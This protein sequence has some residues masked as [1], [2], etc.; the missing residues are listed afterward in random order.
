MRL[1]IGRI[2]MTLGNH[3]ETHEPAFDRLP[4]VFPTGALT[5]F[6]ERL[7]RYAYTEKN[8]PI[9][10]AIEVGIRATHLW[11][12]GARSAGPA[13]PERVSPQIEAQACA[14]TAQWNAKE[15]RNS[16]GDSDLSEPL[17][18]WTAVEVEEILRAHVEA[19]IYHEGVPAPDDDL[20][21]SEEAI[22]ALEAF[23]GN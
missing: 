9:A 22:I 12:G 23:I 7:A 13:N 2:P 4:W 11:C 5:P 10:S 17:V 16:D 18:Q 21:L 15:R 1:Y 8:L 19:G 6:L 14:A 3:Q 20:L